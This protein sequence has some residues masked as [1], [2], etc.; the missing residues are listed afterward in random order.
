MDGS[1]HSFKRVDYSN[2]CMELSFTDLITSVVLQK[3]V[4][5]PRDSGSIVLHN[6]NAYINRY[7]YT[8]LR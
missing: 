1:I 8:F 2:F 7:S 5:C 4:F 6:H 3:H